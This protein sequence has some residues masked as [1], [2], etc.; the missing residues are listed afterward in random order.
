MT[1]NGAGAVLTA[2]NLAHDWHL[3]LSPDTL[4]AYIRYQFIRLYENV[5]DWEAPAHNRKRT[6]WDG[7]K[8][9]FGVKH[10]STWIKAARLVRD[11]KADPG[12]WVAAHFS[13][14][15]LM[16]SGAQTTGLPEMRPTRLCSGQSIE[17]YK[18]YCEQLPSIL[19]TNFEIAGSTLAKRIRATESFNLSPDDQ[20]FYCVCDGSVVSA[21]PFFRHAFAA[22]LN[23]D[24]GVEEYLWLAALDYEA[25]QKIYDIAV[26]PWCITDAL[27]FAVLEIRQHWEQ[28]R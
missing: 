12:L 9:Q 4:A 5:H 23:C 24:R 16:R 13:A 10:T 1:R 17:I 18:D 8:D 19:R 7:G 27:K 22:Q 26:E 11:N 20:V 6:Q 21:S 15:G 14:I 28:Y 2:N 25:Q 3:R